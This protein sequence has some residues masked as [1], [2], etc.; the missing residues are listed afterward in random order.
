MSRWPALRR[1]R[2]RT[3]VPRAVVRAR[4]LQGCRGCRPAPRTCTSPP[5]HGQPFLARPL[6]HLQVAAIRPRACT[7]SRPTGSRFSRVH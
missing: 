7:S 4:P 5:S 1:E 6:K 2:A 3:L